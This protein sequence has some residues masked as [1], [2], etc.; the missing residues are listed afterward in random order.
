M[1]LVLGSGYVA[2]ALERELQARGSAH[3]LVSRQTHDYSIPLVLAGLIEQLGVDFVINAAGF[4]GRPNVDECEDQRVVCMQANV[5]LPIQIK[6]ACRMAGNVPWAHVSSGCIYS[7]GFAHNQLVEDLSLLGRA[8][9]IRG[10]TEQDEPNFV[11]GRRCSFYSGCKALAEQA[12]QPYDRCFVWRI[13]IPFDEFSGPRNYINKLWSYKKVYLS[14]NSL[15]HMG[16]FARAAI[17]LY[18]RRF[19]VPWGIYNMTNPGHIHTLD[20]VDAIKAHIDPHWQHDCWTESGFRQAVRAPRSNCVLD[21]SKLA[22]VGI[23]MRPVREALEA[24]ASQWQWL[25]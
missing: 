12:L 24:A 14:H 19:S 25:T 18:E 8:Q 22:R 7:G 2:R 23:Q 3:R 17:D 5:I 11:F 15:T 9:Q 13:R 1:I 10:F 21:S 20:A 16:D 6:N 4:T